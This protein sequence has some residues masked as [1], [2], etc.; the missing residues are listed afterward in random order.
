MPA[1]H[2]LKGFLTGDEKPPAKTILSKDDKG[3]QVHLHNPNYSQWIARD[4]AILGYL[5]SSLSRETL[6]SIA[7]CIRAADVW[8]EPS[9]L[10]SSQV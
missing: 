10:Y 1:I 9:K 7:T 5:L 6:V 4:Q 8:K 3:Q 2:K